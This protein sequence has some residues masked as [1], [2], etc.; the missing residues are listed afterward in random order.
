MKV[1]HRSEQ[2]LL[3]IAALGAGLEL[4]DF[5]LFAVMAPILA[6]Y[7]FPQDNPTV[8]LLASLGTFASGFLIRPLT[9]IFWGYLGDRFGRKTALSYTLLAMAI[10]TCLIAVLPTYEHVGVMA[11]VLLLL[12]RLFQGASMSGECNGAMIFM[13]EHHGPAQQGRIAGLMNV[14]GT[15][16]VLVATALGILMDFPGMPP[17]AWRS[18]FLLG[19]LIGLLGFWVRSRLLETPAYLAL[20]ERPRSLHSPFWEACHH[21]RAAWMTFMQAGLNGVVTYTMIGFLS[22]YL[23]RYLGCSKTVVLAASMGV[24]LSSALVEW[25][26]G[27]CLDRLPLK[28]AIQG[29]LILS[30][31]L[32][33]LVFFGF[34][35]AGKLGFACSIFSG[36]ILLG[37]WAVVTHL[38]IQTLFPV[39]HR[40]TGVAFFY[41]LG[42]SLIGGTTP[43]VL[44]SLIEWSHALWVPLWYFLGALGFYALSFFYLGGP[45]E[46][47]PE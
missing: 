39:G 17:W 38:F 37:S 10:P 23:G 42:M 13:L 35:D 25:Q 14:I 12:A 43:L 47:S 26:F 46:S 11:T 9:A 34:Q 44:T 33:W 28:R 40:Y 29:L 6:L 36:G 1:Q 7:F 41:N 5:T 27:C 2:N 32:G 19:A 21:R 22:L 45:Y 8:A 16:G 18:P 15:G 4:Y 24:L 20:L 30:P 31:I 3:W